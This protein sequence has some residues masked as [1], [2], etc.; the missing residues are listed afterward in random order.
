[1]GISGTQLEIT[2]EFSGTSSEPFGVSVLSG[3]GG[4][5][6]L[7]VDQTRDYVLIDGTAQGNPKPRA[8]PILGGADKVWMHAFVDG[9]TIEVIFNNQTAIT[10]QVY[11]KAEGGG[12]EIFGTGKGVT[13]ELNA[14]ALEQ[15]NNL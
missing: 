8:G 15:A 2:A 1:M 3:S 4:K 5:T 11:P 12:V 7:V 9:N 14:W 10:T 13:V 6:N